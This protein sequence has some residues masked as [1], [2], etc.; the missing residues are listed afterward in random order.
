MVAIQP[1]LT[2][3]QQEIAA[4]TRTLRS[5][6]WDRSRFDIEFGLRNGTT[7]NAFLVRGER[8]AL[9]DSSHAKFRSSWIPALQEMVDPTTIDVLIVSHTE[10]DHS[11]L[12]GDLLDLNPEIEVVGSKVAINY[13]QSHG[14]FGGGD[15]ENS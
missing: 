4:D 12:I 7:Y 13:L 1:R 3:Q 10:P 11:G 15:S 9:I 6:D 2:L 8:T 5:L 14:E